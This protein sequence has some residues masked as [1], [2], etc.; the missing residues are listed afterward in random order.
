MRDL[1]GRT[2]VV[3][4][5]ASGMGRGIA[6]ALADAGV[7]VVVSDIEADG[8]EEVA[9]EVAQRGVASLAVDADMTDVT[10]VEALA[11]AAYERF[12]RVDILCNNAGVGIK[13]WRALW[14]HTLEDWRFAI[15]G[16][17]WSTIHGMHVFVPRMRA[18]DGEKHIVNTSSE[19]TLQAPQGL[20]AYTAAKAGVTAISE[21]AAKELAADGFGV[22]IFTPGAVTTRIGTSDRLRPSAERAEG[23]DLPPFES[24]EVAHYLGHPELYLDPIDVG[25]MVR[26]AIEVGQ[27]YLLTHPLPDAVAWRDE[28]LRLGPGIHEKEQIDG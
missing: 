23:R 12:G 18:Q 24:P 11:D 14:N 4:G 28:E 13:P 20:M 16:N 1:R 6:L 10:A 3:T 17:L 8:A 7:D 25:V 5:A 9:R 22:T 15:D 21:I 19:A 2:A 26:Q 27:V